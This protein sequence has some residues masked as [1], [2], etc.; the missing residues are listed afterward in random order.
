MTPELLEL[1]NLS[2]PYLRADGTYDPGILD[3]AARYAQIAATRRER[4]SDIVSDL[5]DLLDGQANA[6]GEDEQILAALIHANEV[7][8]GGGGDCP[9]PAAIE[10]LRRRWGG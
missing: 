9:I 10:L 7:D 1:A 3:I 2:M 6:R 5:L 4:E 8:D